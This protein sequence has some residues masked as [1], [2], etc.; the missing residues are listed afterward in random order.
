MCDFG[1]FFFLGVA[2]VSPCAP[3]MS[4]AAVC[5][6]VLAWATCRLTKRARTLQLIA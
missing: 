2:M 4:W 1:A 3:V 6:C 5:V